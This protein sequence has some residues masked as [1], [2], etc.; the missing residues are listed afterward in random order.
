MHIRCPHCQNPIEVVGNEEFASVNCPSCGSAFD[1]VP[2]TAAYT[3]ETRTIAHFELL[4]QLGS[5]GF[6][7]VWKARDAKLDR[8]V[9]IKVP[10]ID[11]QDR[12]N[13]EMFLREAR[14]AAQLRHP[15]IVAV[16]EVGRED[17]TLYIVS[18]FIEG[19]SFPTDSPLA[20]LRRANRLLC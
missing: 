3:P 2:K 5:G 18:D 6:G 11:R 1:L 17:D 14:A 7:T 9:A 15:H 19:V 8:L 20:R 13:G 12:N 16:H 10:R 4:Q